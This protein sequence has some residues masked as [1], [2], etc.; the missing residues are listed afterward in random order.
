MIFAKSCVLNLPSCYFLAKKKSESDE[1]PKRS[2][3]VFV[4]VFDGGCVAPSALLSRG[5]SA[6]LVDVVSNGGADICARRG[7]QLR[8]ADLSIAVILPRSLA[9]L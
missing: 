4:G 8:F 1:I 7:V 6:E 5:L 9:V 2:L 3:V